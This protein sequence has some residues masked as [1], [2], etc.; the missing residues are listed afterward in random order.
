VLDLLAPPAC[1]ACLAPTARGAP[2]CAPCA[3][4]LPW[5]DD[6]C[7][8]CALP[9]CTRCPHERKAFDAAYAPLAHAGVA[10][11]LLLA[12]KLRRSR[13]AAR[14]MAAHVLGRAPAAVFAGATVVP[15]PGR[16]SEHLAEALARATRRPVVRCL[17]RDPGAATRQVGRA[18]PERLARPARGRLAVTGRAP[19]AA[20][21]VL[22][23]D[24]H[25]TG[26]TLHSGALT[27]RDAGF[28][29][30]AAVTYVRTLTPA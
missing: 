12:L 30:V 5:I 7:P 3:G 20:S 25:T 2:L 6:P 16:A 22:V 29:R 18:R 11:D 15:V 8:R 9:R 27:L 13:A 23:D 14:A 26:A 17:T 24:V 19:P 21:A 28:L 1:L 10:R 4:A